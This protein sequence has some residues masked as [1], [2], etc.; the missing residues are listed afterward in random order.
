VNR[1][2]ERANTSQ[3]LFGLIS[4]LPEIEKEDAPNVEV[5]DISFMLYCG[6]FG[7]FLV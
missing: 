7:V 5:C 6:V 4:E 2:L 3:R 1:D